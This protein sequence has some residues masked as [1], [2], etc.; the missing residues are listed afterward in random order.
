M[1]AGFV[2]TLLS[3]LESDYAG[4]DL[5]LLAA[6]TL[7]TSVSSAGASALVQKLLCSPLAR[8][9]CSIASSSTKLSGTTVCVC[10]FEFVCV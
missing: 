2:S 10:V 3:E 5:K 9:L 6:Q 8:N 1:L 4:R 7:C